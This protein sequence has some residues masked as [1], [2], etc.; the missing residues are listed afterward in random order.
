MTG[1][2]APDACHWLW[3]QVLQ[4]ALAV[5]E[6]CQGCEPIKQLWDHTPLPL[7]AVQQ[8]QQ[9]PRAVGKVTEVLGSPAKQRQQRPLDDVKGVQDVDC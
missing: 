9:Q 6:R 1:G 3:L 2:T 4:E 7:T 5:V 8:Q